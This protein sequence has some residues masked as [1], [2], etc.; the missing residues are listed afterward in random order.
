[1]NIYKS[2][3]YT[4]GSKAWWKNIVMKVKNVECFFGIILPTGVMEY[5]KHIPPAP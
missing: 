1:M 3:P 4:L 2:T 5:W